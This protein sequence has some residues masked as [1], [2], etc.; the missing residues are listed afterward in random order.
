MTCQFMMWPGSGYCLDGPFSVSSEL[1][2]KDNLEYAVELL[3]AYLLERG[4]RNYYMTVTEYDEWCKECG[5]DSDDDME[6]WLYVDGTMEGA[7]E[8]IYI[9]TENLKYQ[10]V[11]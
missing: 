3:A 7:S 5:W 6:G 9:R 4:P 8:P 1:L 2:T 10:F 11:A